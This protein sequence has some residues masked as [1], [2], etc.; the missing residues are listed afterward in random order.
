MAMMAMTTKSSIK[1][2][3]PGSLEPDE[4]PRSGREI[5]SFEVEQILEKRAPK[6]PVPEE[7]EPVDVNRLM[8]SRVVFIPGLFRFLEY[9][10]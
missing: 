7:S 10:I 9:Y 8:E 5:E 4:R 3:A 1:V 6:Q 2:N